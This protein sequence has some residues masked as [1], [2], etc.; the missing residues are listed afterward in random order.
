MTARQVHAVI[1]AGL[2]DPTLVAQW[3]KD[4]QVLVAHGV[5]PSAIDLD[6]LKKF[7]GLTVK[8]RHNLLRDL[9]PLTFR[10][11]NVAVLE[12]VVFSAYSVHRANAGYAPTTAERA[13]DLIDF[14]GQWL[15][16]GNLTHAL[17]WDLIR[18]EHTLW[19][20]AEE[21]PVLPSMALPSH[22]MRSR[23]PRIRGTVVLHEMQC[24]P[25]ELSAMLRGS[26]PLLDR[27][28]T[29]QRFFCYQRDGG[30]VRM[31]ELDEFGYFALTFTDG[32]RST[33]SISRA[34]GLGEPTP[35]FRA[36]FQQLSEAGLL[37][38]P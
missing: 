12:I 19:S 11:M 1:A 15:D 3:C 13:R 23:A 10:L 34:L 31:I 33:A 28:E 22:S 2:A 36:L 38:V 7:A 35:T 9:L 27:I 16:R 21:P 8:V 29:A 20:A 17:L 25:R 6:A 5:E 32:H 4:P 26:K 18:H 14:L 24:D 30:E 37:R